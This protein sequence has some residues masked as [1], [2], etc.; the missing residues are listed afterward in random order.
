MTIPVRILC[1]SVAA[2]VL[3]LNVAATEAA[4]IDLS[5]LDV[6]PNPRL[7]LAFPGS[8]TEYYPLI[9]GAG[10]G[11]AR[12]SVAWGRVEPRE[13]RFDWRGLDSRVA[14][15]QANGIE[16]FLTFESNADWATVPAT[17]RV[18]NA[19]PRDPATWERFVRT[20]VD[21]YD[22]DG[23]NDMPGLDGRVRYWQA[24]NE[25]ISDEN[26][27]GGWVGSADDLV[28]YVRSAHDAV[29]AE[30]PDAIFV[31]GGLAAFNVDVLTVARGGLDMTVRQKWDAGS[32]TVLTVRDMRGPEIARIIDR[33]VL[34]VI[35]RS[36][37]DFAAV[38]LYGPEARDAGRIGFVRALTGRPVLSSECGGPSL[39]YGGR[40]TPEDHFRAV[41]E[42][43]L[44]VWAA[45]AEFCLW[46]LLGEGPGATFGNRRTALYTRDA[47]PKPGVFAYR[48]LA[49]V[50]DMSTSV[51]RTGTD[52]FTLRR[53][54][55]ETLWIGW[56]GGAAAARDLAMRNGAEVLCLEDARSGRLGGDPDRCDENALVL[57]GHNLSTLLA[58]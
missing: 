56:N 36:P 35:S 39:D 49:R 27:S 17:R 1:R 52:L 13:G 31:L 46:F 29:K 9:S 44:G 48:M 24:A 15:L 33:R 3:A 22:S 47:E 53:G 26:G 16:P 57:G 54:G 11:I 12:I 28:A 7:G 23:R 43:N 18:R 38:H 21:R 8:R 37:Y 4:E 41:V 40:Y 55:G 34:P 20:V 14:A 25:W 2:C 32:E 51:A 45:G 42:R 30:D 10:I 19:R 5:K 58:L 50:I 6:T